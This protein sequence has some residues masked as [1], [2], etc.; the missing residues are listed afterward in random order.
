M[1]TECFVQTASLLLTAYDALEADFDL[2]DFE[3]TLAVRDQIDDLFK[4][5]TS[6]RVFT[7]ADREHASDLARSVLRGAR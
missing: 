3:L 6:D 1:T 2:N 4:A 7:E 5:L